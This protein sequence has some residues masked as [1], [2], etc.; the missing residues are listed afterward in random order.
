MQQRY[1]NLNTDAKPT[2]ELHKV[3]T[4][5]EEWA[6]KETIKCY[7]CGK[8][9]AGCPMAFAMNHSPT[10]IMRMVQQGQIEKALRSNTIW[11]CSACE[12]CTT[13][14][15]QEV[16]IA[17]VMDSLRNSAFKKGYVKQERK[18]TLA[19]WS[20]LRNMKTFGRV[21][22]PLLVF[23]YNIISGQPFKDTEKG[24]A[25]L[26]KGKLPFFPKTIRGAKEVRRIF[27]NIE[28]MKSSSFEQHTDD[29]V[30]P[31]AQKEDCCK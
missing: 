1:N 20:F 23:L 31:P 26:L 4:Q 12:T 16:E 10:Q 27:E 8:C 6:I 21:F 22:E 30:P 2:K 13:R 17:E 9:L 14:C 19:H 28:K 3:R 7:Q 24:P 25:M 18:I 15:P 11:I 29:S 5:N